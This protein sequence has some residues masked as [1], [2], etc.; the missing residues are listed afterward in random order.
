VTS[1]QVDAGMHPLA[2]LLRPRWPISVEDREGVD[3][4]RSGLVVCGP[5]DEGRTWLQHGDWRIYTRVAATPSRRGE[6]FATFAREDGREI[7]ATIGPED[8]E[9]VVPFSFADAYEAYVSEAWQASSANRR[10]SEGS[11]NAFYRVKALVPRRLQLAARR[12]L[13]RTQGVPVFP[14]WPADMSVSRL[15]RFFAECTL[16]AAGVDEGRF[17]WFW[18]EGNRAAVVLTHDVESADGIRRVF[19]VADVEEAHGFRSSFNFGGWY[20]VDPG[21]LRELTARGFEV[22]MHGLTHDRQLFA[23]REAFNERLPELARLAERLGAVGFRSPAT[24]RVFSW[25]GELPVDYDCTLPNSDPYEP[26]PGGCCSVWPFMIGTVV[27]LPYTL[28]QDHTLLTLLRHRSPVLWLEQARSI[29][30]EHGLIQCVS[31]PD[32]GYLG[33]SDKRAIY[34]EFLAGLADETDLWRALPREV[35]SWWRR[36]AGAAGA[37][38]GLV[39]GIARLGADGDVELSLA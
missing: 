37:G 11:L 33:D 13:I 17:L 30:R 2:Q 7:A 6:P 10:L 1:L 22:G 26:Q 3:D 12:R 8:R 21:V 32:A 34:S 15:V 5:R 29:Q 24:H 27:E 14:A 4:R 38:E 25:L 16:R 23:S 20:D 28:P 31:H 36:R 35:A 39:E 18:P 19:D 9:I